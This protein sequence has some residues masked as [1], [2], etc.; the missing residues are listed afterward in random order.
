MSSQI[1]RLDTVD[2]ALRNRTY[3]IPW[4]SRQELLRWV[5]WGDN[6]S[7]VIAPFEAA[8][9][10]QPV[11]LRKAEKE[12]LGQLIERWAADAGSDQLPPGVWRLR[13]ELFVDLESA[14]ENGQ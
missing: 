7:P 2:I 5:R 6:T 1:S 4:E 12:L 9:A 13:E 10:S 11:T 14:R 3:G 8:G